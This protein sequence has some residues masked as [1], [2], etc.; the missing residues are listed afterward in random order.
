MKNWLRVSLV[1]AMAVLV[2][3]TG[4][5]QNYQHGNPYYNYYAQQQA[6]A[7]YYYAMQQQAMA[8]RYYQQYYYGQPV[9]TSPSVQYVQ[10]APHQ[11]A[12]P[13]QPEQHQPV[14]VPAPTEATAHPVI[15]HNPNGAVAGPPVIPTPAE[16]EAGQVVA[17]PAAEVVGGSCADGTCGACVDGSCGACVDGSCG[18]CD[19][20]PPNAP[21]ALPP[22]CRHWWISA[23]GDYMY[24]KARGADIPLGV[25]IDGAGNFRGPVGMAAPD[26]SSGFRAG[27]AGSWDNGKTILQGTYAWFNSDTDAN[28]VATPPNTFFSS[29]FAL[30]NPATTIASRYD[31]DFQ[32][33]DLDLKRGIWQGPC[34]DV[35]V[36]VGGRYGHL[37]QDF[38]ATILD[39]GGS[40]TTIDSKIGFDAGGPRIGLAGD[41]VL[42]CGVFVFGSGSANILFGRFNANY[43]STNDMNAFPNE[44]VQLDSDRV[45]P[46][47]ELELGVGWQSPKGRLR[48][49]GGYMVSAWFNTLTTPD[50]MNAINTGNFT[51]D[52]GDT[53]TFDGLFGRVEF[54]Y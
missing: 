35:F 32:L 30:P 54:R 37:D 38:Y 44:L 52:L 51:G 3:G 39:N 4:S 23:F 28:L 6:Y 12:Y 31:V 11:S 2:Q 47:L 16:V 42:K 49:Q 48:L 8:Q 46:V 45:V 24:L 33:F 34:G 15:E 17:I 36:I 27:L 9:H 43:Q 19:T 26:Y 14:P 7:R 21:C 20:C 5:A 50:F 25:E 40:T 29:L 13:P 10:P 41:F 1:I 53:L 22:T 18:V